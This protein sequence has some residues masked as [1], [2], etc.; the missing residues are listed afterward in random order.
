[1]NKKDLTLSVIVCTYNRYEFLKSCLNSLLKQS[2]SDFEVVVVDNFGEMRLRKLVVAIDGGKRFRYIHE[3][4]VGLSNARNRGA[5]ESRGKFLAYIDDDA[6]ATNAWVEKIIKR[7]ESSNTEVLGGPILPWYKERKPDWFKDA[8]ELRS[9]GNKVRVLKENEFLSG[10]NMVLKRTQ[11]LRCGFSQHKGMRGKTIGA[12][13]EVE[14]QQEL[15]DKE[16]VKVWYDPRIRVEHAVSKK[17]YSLFYKLKRSFYFGKNMTKE[18]MHWG[19]RMKIWVEAGR[20]LAII[21]GLLIYRDI[22][23]YPHWQNFVYE[24]VSRIV[25]RLGTSFA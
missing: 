17:N 25:F 18:D 20:D 24:E 7:L 22:N 5:R 2:V 1:M 8:Y 23:K 16:G 19:K 10:S 4:Q 11:V 14:L 21:P 6:R 12:G 9:H 15:R 3:R 13:E